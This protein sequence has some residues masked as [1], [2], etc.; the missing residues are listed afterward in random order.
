MGSKLK[1]RARKAQAK[2][3]DQGETPASTKAQPPS[4]NGAKPQDTQTGAKPAAVGTKAEVASP[5]PKPASASDTEAQAADTNVVSIGTKAVESLS[6]AE[7]ADFV[8]RHNAELERTEEPFTASL[9]ATRE[10]KANQVQYDGKT[11]EGYAIR[12]WAPE[13][14]PMLIGVTLTEA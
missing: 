8:A 2:G 3:A 1:D 14:S 7:V 12:V 13:G 4:K 9:I 11:P 6:D 10:T 5:D